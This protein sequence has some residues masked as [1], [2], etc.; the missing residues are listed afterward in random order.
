MSI[1]IVTF[2]LCTGV[3]LVYLCLNMLTR[4]HRFRV[5]WVLDVQFESPVVEP[6]DSIQKWIGKLRKMRRENADE[7]CCTQ[8][9]AYLSVPVFSEVGVGPLEDGQET[10]KHLSGRDELEMNSD[11]NDCYVD[12][13]HDSDL[14]DLSSSFIVDRSSFLKENGELEYFAGYDVYSNY[15]ER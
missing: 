7:E 10:K 8:L 2:D 6:F 14:G 11:Y 9:I 12:E 4:V 5:L 13:L 15:D 1:C 3:E